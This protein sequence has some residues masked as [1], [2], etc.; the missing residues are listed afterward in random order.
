VL[1]EL[2]E[3]AGRR[4]T[5]QGLDL[6]EQTVRYSVDVRYHGQGFEIPVDVDPAWLADADGALSRLAQTF[7]AEHN[8]L[9][10]FLLEVDHEM[11]NARATVSGPRPDVAPVHLEEGDS[12]P[13]A[14]LVDT[15]VIHVSGGKVDAQVYD[16]AKLRAGD[17]ARGPAIV[18]EMDSTTLVLPGHAATVHASGS[19]LINPV[20]G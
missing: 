1:R 18:T 2:A 5:E 16:R 3:E 15:H 13:A 19:L 11:V 14:A 4:L 8:R 6:G 17:V 9:F 12:D 7:D 20:E 10:S